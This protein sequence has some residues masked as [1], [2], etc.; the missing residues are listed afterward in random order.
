[1]KGGRDQE[2]HWDARQ[3]A[4]DRQELIKLVPD[5]ESDN[6]GESDDDGTRQV[7]AHLSLA[8]LGPAIGDP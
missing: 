5:G 1:M 8:S 2:R 4:C 7:L 6:T 3:C